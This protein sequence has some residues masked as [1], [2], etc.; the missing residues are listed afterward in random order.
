MKK[1]SLLS[2]AICLLFVLAA[3]GLEDTIY[4]TEETTNDEGKTVPIV[5]AAKCLNSEDE[6]LLSRGID[7]WLLKEAFFGLRKASISLK[8]A[9]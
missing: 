5:W 4:E 9:M 8:S 3:S 7:V 1:Q 2:Y 6:S